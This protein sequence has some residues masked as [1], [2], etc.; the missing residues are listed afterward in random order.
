[1]F[2]TREPLAQRA[3]RSR[4]MAGQDSRTVNPESRKHLGTN[5]ISVVGDKFPVVLTKVANQFRAAQSGTCAAGATTPSKHVSPRP[6]WEK[7]ACCTSAIATP[8]AAM[9]KQ[10]RWNRLLDN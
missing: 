7:C 10:P 1:M 9:N 4:V 5:Y 6:V 8:H 3:H 2:R